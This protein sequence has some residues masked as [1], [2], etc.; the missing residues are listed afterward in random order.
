MLQQFA[1]AALFLTLAI[2]LIHRAQA[3]DP[4]LLKYKLEKGTQSFTRHNATNKTTQKING[5]NIESEITQVSIHVQASDDV[6]A[7]GTAKLKTKTERLKGTTKITGLGDYEFD[8]QKPDRDKSSV[9]GAALTP[10]YER[11]VGSDLQAEV[12]PHGTVKSLTGY[13]QLVGD[14]IKDNPLTAQFAGGGTDN[15][16]K[17]GAQAQ[18]IVFPETAVKPG[19]K[20]DNPYEMEMAGL[21]V[22]KGKET[23]TFVAVEQR[24]THS[25][26]KL[27]ISNDISF[28]LKIDMGAA[29]VSGKVTTSSSEGS[30]EFD[31][32]TG[33]LVSQKSKLTLTGQLSVV[34][35]NMTIPV[36]LTQVIESEQ[37]SLDKLPE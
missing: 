16:A 30:A 18:W 22:V 23:V 19:E 21:G 34:V 33:K 36:D 11:I 2:G 1:R 27:S 25:I 7:E 9:L 6:D 20:W 31:I 14:L 28:D 4:I 15:A 35:N 5:T 29:K 32:T 12:T 24:D 3:Q 13:A 8:S 37:T 26:A 17:L 10:L